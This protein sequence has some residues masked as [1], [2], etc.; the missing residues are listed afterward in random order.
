[1]F[2]ASLFLLFELWRVVCHSIHLEW[3]NITSQTTNHSTPL[4]IY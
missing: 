2:G 3:N 4:H 1:M